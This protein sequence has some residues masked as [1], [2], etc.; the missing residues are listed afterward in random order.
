MLFLFLLFFCICFYC[1]ICV[2]KR[3]MRLYLFE[4][5]EIWADSEHLEIDGLSA[6]FYIREDG[7]E[8]KRFQR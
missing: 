5:E 8:I 2:I 1:F 3:E 6:P 4:K 7:V